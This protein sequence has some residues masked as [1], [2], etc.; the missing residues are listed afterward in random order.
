MRDV[1][2][3][4]I[5]QTPVGEHW[6]RSL[7]DLAVEAVGSALRDASLSRVDALFVGNML[8]GELSHQEHLGALITD[9]IGLRGIEAA[10]SEASDASGGLALRQ[11]Y[12]A[13]ASSSV[14]TALVLGVEKFTDVVGSARLSAL[15]AGLDVEYESTHGAT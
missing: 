7:S 4:G 13:V 5:G 6:D 10:R 2:I 1:N 15:V 3:I 12:L 8:A 14:E 11:A 9:Q